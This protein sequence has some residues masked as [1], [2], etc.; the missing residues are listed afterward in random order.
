MIALKGRNITAQVDRPGYGMT[1]LIS[2]LKGSAPQASYYPFTILNIH[3]RNVPTLQAG[4]EMAI[5]TP[6]LTTWA[7]M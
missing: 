6:G 1:P 3:S 5:L 7:I 4:N 2:G